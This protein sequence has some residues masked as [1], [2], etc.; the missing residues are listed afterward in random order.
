MMSWW[1]KK[2]DV[3]LVYN[4]Q[5]INNWCLM[6]IWAATGDECLSGSCRIFTCRFNPASFTLK[7]T[8]PSWY[9]SFAS[10]K[11]AWLLQS[12][13]LHNKNKSS[14][15][16]CQC[17]EDQYWNIPDL[18]EDWTHC[19]WVIR[20]LMYH[21]AG[22]RTICAWR[23]DAW[24]TVTSDFTIEPQQSHNTDPVRASAPPHFQTLQQTSRC[25][26]R[27][28]LGSNPDLPWA[29]WGHSLPRAACWDMQRVK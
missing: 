11:S 15:V 5:P 8:T 29:E 22:R 7:G 14:A 16:S 6:W 17:S 2:T 24:V 13:I 26:A 4:L 10:S 21:K 18:R 23:V 1:K 9:Y 19:L 3:D 20:L 27:R 25:G 12:V 28:W